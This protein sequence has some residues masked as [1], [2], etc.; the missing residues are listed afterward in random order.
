MPTVSGVLSESVVTSAREVSDIENVMSWKSPS[1]ERLS[2]S[3][4]LEVTE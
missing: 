3:R 4:E 2:S 1:S